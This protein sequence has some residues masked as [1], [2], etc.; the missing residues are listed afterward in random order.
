MKLDLEPCYVLHTQAFKETSL[1]AQ[2]L[3]YQHGRISVLAKGAKRAKSTF[4]GLLYPFVPLQCS[5]VGRGDLLTLT[6][7]EAGRAFRLQG[8][9][10]I[11]GMYINELIMKLTHHHD[12]VPQI[13]ECYQQAMHNVSQKHYPLNWHLRLF[14]IQFLEAL[15]YG[16]DW[17]LDAA[18]Q[19]IELTQHYDY[20]PEQGFVRAAHERTPLTGA[21]IVALMNKQY[22]K[23]YMY[24]SKWLMHKAIES[25]LNGKTLQT[26]ALFQQTG[27]SL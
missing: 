18:N 10:L 9:D 8:Q 14:E 12:P 27:D 1:I 22:H 19:P 16:F 3:T 7:I 26:R 6:Q 4:R 13:Y 17:K 23:E 11:A 21:V 24:A 5:A 25:I 15:G 2:L 20:H